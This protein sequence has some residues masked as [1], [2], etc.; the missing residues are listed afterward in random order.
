MILMRLRAIFLISVL[1]LFSASSLLAAE[2]DSASRFDISLRPYKFDLQG[3]LVRAIEDY[4][5]AVNQTGIEPS[6]DRQVRAETDRLRQL[7]D[8]RGYYQAQITPAYDEER[9]KPRYRIVLGPQ[10]QI[11]D[12]RLQGDLT[13]DENDWQSLEVGDPLS[14]V[15]VLAQQGQ[16]RSYLAEQS[17]Y[18]RLTVNH[19]V[20]LNDAERTARVT[21]L[22]KAELP[23]T[24][25]EI[26]FTGAEG[27]D[28]AF[29][30]RVAGLSAN[31]C[32]RRSSIDSAVISLFDTGLFR[33]VRPKFARDTQGRVPV[34]FALEMRKSRTISASIGWKSEQGLGLKAGW[35]HRNLFSRAQ[36]LS[37]QGQLQSLEQSLSA[38]IVFPSFFDRRNRLTWRN[39]I[40]HQNVDLESYRFN[41]TANLE[42]K[43]SANN[44]FDYGIGF[45]QI[46]ERQDDTWDTFQQLRVPARYRFDS[47]ADPFNPSGGWR[48]SLLVEPIFDIRRDFAPF[49]NV[50]L[51]TQ[52]FLPLDDRLTLATRVR[53]SG[54]VV[55]GLLES[56]YANVPDSERFTAGGSTSVRG[57][58]YQSLRSGQFDENGNE[59]GGVTRVLAVNELRLKFNDSWGAVGFL[60]SGRVG[61]V[62]DSTGGAPW[63]QGAGFGLRYYT[64]FAP[65]RFDVAFP[66]DAR[67]SDSRF[68]I[69]VSLGQA[70]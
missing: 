23:S 59:L 67:E 60:D 22:V 49:F 50:S 61:G 58:P 47:V 70:F 5:T 35:Q 24:F 52:V 34:S 12:I 33:Q 57:Y 55:G 11:A 7:L 16:L 64:R 39:E 54:L 14:A 53:G 31:Q 40:S 30:A 42:R 4:R 8:S 36:S 44:F 13:P 29:L 15:R 28:E 41:T 1:F 69:Y 63:Y 65:I 38:Q 32:Y 43:A 45:E 6:Q 18:Y 48:W 27:V 3:E 37:F 68:Q 20:Q 46:D 26:S 10:Y 25:G 66:L 21:Y 9:G 56:S 62:A 17:C 51:G 2:L 19:E